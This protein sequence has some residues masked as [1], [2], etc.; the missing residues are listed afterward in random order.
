MGCFKLQ[1]LSFTKKRHWPH[2]TAIFVIWYTAKPGRPTKKN[3]ESSNITKRRKPE[4]LKADFR[5][6]LK[7][8]T[9]ILDFTDRLFS[10][11]FDRV[12]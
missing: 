7:R 2:K 11:K 8:E 6:T 1:K 10:R 5:M 3:G 4:N 9:S 12:K